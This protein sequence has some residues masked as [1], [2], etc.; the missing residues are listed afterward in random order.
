MVRTEEERLRSMMDMFR[1]Y[2]ALAIESGGSP[3]TT[4][5][6]C[7]ERA[8]CI[9]YRM[10]QLKEE[11]AW[12]FDARRNQRKE[13]VEGQN[14]NTNRGSR[15]NYKPNQSTNFKKNGKPY[16]QGSQN[17]QPQR[18]NPQNYL[19]CKKCEKTHPGECQARN[20]NVC[21]RCG[22]EGHYAKQSPNPPNY[23]NVPALNKNST[24]KV[25]AMQAKLEGPS[26]S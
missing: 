25:Y 16:G 9:E 17:N 20:P 6:R 5:A 11:R 13:G 15:P 26:I 23:E 8:I 12:N 19:V 7:V 4:V 24:P 21:Y 22:K 2:I 3:P 1:P 18:K 14:K 10:T